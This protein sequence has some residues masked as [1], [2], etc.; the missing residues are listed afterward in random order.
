MDFAIIF[1]KV[2]D[3]FIYYCSK[4]FT[5][6]GFTTTVGAFFVWCFLAALVISILKGLAD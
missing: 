1:K 6:A 3:F 2:C 5:F 4:E